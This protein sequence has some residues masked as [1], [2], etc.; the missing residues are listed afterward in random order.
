MMVDDNQLQKKGVNLYEPVWINLAD[1]PQPL[2]LVV[3]EISKNEIKGYLSEPK[4]KKA[5]LDASTPPAKPS[6]NELEP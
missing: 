3:N 1:R 4:Y 5:D 6:N 2:E